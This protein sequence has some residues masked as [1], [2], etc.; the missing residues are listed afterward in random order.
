MPCI[1]INSFILG[2]IVP[3]LVGTTYLDEVVDPADASAKL[4]FV[5]DGTLVFTPSSGIPATQAGQWLTGISST[6]AALYELEVVITS[7]S[8][9]DAVGTTAAGAGTWRDLASNW[10]YGNI[11]TTIGSKSTTA[12]FTIRRK[13]DTVTMATASIVITALVTT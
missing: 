9:Y 3:F 8:A 1:T 12:T 4:Q 13:S 11:R 6:E 10:M 7:G 2:S 5:N